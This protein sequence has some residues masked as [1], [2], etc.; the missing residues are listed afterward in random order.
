MELIT[1]KSGTRKVLADAVREKSG[2][3]GGLVP[4]EIIEAIKQL[5]G[6]QVHTGT[7]VLDA[8]SPAIVVPRLG[9]L[10]HVFSPDVPEKVGNVTSVVWEKGPNEN[11]SWQLAVYGRYKAVDPLTLTESSASAFHSLA[12]NT[13]EF[14]TQNAER[15]FAAGATYVWVA[16]DWQGSYVAACYDVSKEG[17]GN[18][19]LILLGNGDGTYE[20]QLRGEGTTMDFAKG[21]KPWQAY[22]DAITSITVGDGITAI[23]NR[24]FH[25]HEAVRQLH[26][27]DS[28]KI[29]HLGERAFQGCQFGGEYSFPNLEDAELAAVFSHCTKLRGLTLNDNVKGIAAAALSACLSLQYVHGISKVV[30][31]G[32][33]AF[34]DAPKLESLDLDPQ[35]CE[36]VHQSAFRLSGAMRYARTENWNTEFLSDAI[37]AENF[38]DLQLEEIRKVGLSN[39]APGE[40]NADGQN[41]YGNIA[42]CK[43][44]G[45]TVSISADGCMALSMYHLYNKIGSSPYDRFAEFW[46]EK[47]LQ[48]GETLESGIDIDINQA[49]EE[50]ARRL[51]WSVKEGFPMKIKDDP[52]SAKRAI[53]DELAAGHG[54]V[55]NLA[56]YVTGADTYGHGVAI[57][58]SNAVTDK[59]IV[60]D[61]IRTSGTKGCIYEMAFEQLFGGIDTEVIFAFEFGGD[62]Q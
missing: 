20:A 11:N 52:A 46:T 4:A 27:E 32:V 21:D 16:Y 54:L 57:V 45:V 9:R 14:S 36:S 6:F 25:R 19:K 48:D 17:E 37:P 42:F 12:D 22:V 34:I 35:V 55:A 26:F 28:S 13:I 2:L 15:V 60:A 31:V 62:S 58:G 8:D 23:G 50:M 44:N 18:V 43:R 1:L 61:S 30:E 56:F 40:V 24:L 5:R 3:T 47:I 29:T 59:L 51:G 10:I 33:G 49:Q 38:S 7:V 41:Q 39:A 53:A